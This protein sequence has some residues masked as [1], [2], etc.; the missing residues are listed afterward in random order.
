M[1]KVDDHGQPDRSINVERRVQRDMAEML[2]L[3]KGILVDGAVVED[4]AFALMTWAE[5]HEDLALAWPGNVLY[6][7]LRKIFDDG[8]A[9]EPEREDLASLLQELVGGGG[10]T[11][12]G[13]TATTGLPLDDPQP[14][15]EI[16][17]RTF[18]FTGR[19]AYGT[20]GTCEEA[21]GES[22][23]GW[24]PASRSTPTIS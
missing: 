5:E 24:N 18:A 9:S 12:G 3:C 19:F 16:P 4:E 20:R 17:N 15:L 6:R 7:R 11:I 13:E 10:G 21:V 2:G 8:Y 1:T 22:V 23:D 14:S